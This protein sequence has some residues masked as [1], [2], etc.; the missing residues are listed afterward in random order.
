MDSRGDGG[1]LVA[2]LD[3]L[4]VELRE[5]LGQRLRDA[6]TD[7]EADEVFLFAGLIRGALRSALDYAES[8]REELERRTRG[9]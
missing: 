5:E 9:V 4:T 2:R 8:V 6:K 3:S 7:V 1:D